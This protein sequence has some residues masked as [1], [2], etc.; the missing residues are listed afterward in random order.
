MTPTPDITQ[1]A[2]PV[3]VFPYPLWMGAVACAVVLALVAALVWF[4]VR[5]MK[6][7]PAPAPPDPRTRALA[8]LDHAR[9]QI[10]ALDPH[11]LTILVSDILRTYISEAFGLRA[12]RQTSPEFLSDA[13][14]STRF[15][16]SEREHLAK[17]LERCDLIKFGHFEAT[18]EDSEQLLEEARSFVLGN[19]APQ[20]PALPVE[21]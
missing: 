8:A 4:V 13:A 21:A 12:T 5:W 11:E 14:T 20:P 10:G 15:A 19:V 1:I 2:P 9:D 3:D 6:N 7:R 18:G 17:F 16:D